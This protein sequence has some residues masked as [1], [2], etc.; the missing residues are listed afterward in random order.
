MPGDSS[1]LYSGAKTRYTRDRSSLPEG[2]F[3]KHLTG[4]MNLKTKLSV[5]K[6]NARSCDRGSRSFRLKK[7]AWHSGPLKELRIAIDV[8]RARMTSFDDRIT[9]MLDRVLYVTGRH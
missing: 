2:T 7:R 1:P 5:S 3:P 6:K 9:D 4:W 8:A